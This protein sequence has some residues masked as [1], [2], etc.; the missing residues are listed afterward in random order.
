M[1]AERSFF[2]KILADNLPLV[3][4]FSRQQKIAG[5]LD[6]AEAEN[7]RKSR[8]EQI[9]SRQTGEFRAHLARFDTHIERYRIRYFVPADGENVE[10]LA[11]VIPDQVY[12]SHDGSSRIEVK[13]D[14][15]YAV[16]IPKE[17]RQEL[18]LGERI[19]L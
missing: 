13:D 10:V 6:D 4:H 1:A 3:S 7:E 2:P 5:I 16:Y 19:K 18:Q 17:K 14:G 11:I 12:D 9:A 8:L 15:R